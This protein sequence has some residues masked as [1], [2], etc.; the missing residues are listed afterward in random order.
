MALRFPN[1]DTGADAWRLVEDCRE[2]ASGRSRMKRW[3]EPQRAIRHEFMQ[4]AQSLSIAVESACATRVRSLR[5]D[6]RG[7]R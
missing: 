7:G 4:A 5:H 2:P 3:R 1:F 6:R